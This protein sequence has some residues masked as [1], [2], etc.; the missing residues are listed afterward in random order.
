MNL[1]RPN[2]QDTLWVE[3]RHFIIEHL[4][5]FRDI[6][7]HFLLRIQ[8]HSQGDGT[9]AGT[10]DDERAGRIFDAIGRGELARGFGG[11]V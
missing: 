4:P 3:V 5:S 7:I 2:T 8:A 1:N 9:G 6:D 11:I 10:L